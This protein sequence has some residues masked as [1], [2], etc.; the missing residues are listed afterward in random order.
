[1]VLEQLEIVPDAPPQAESRLQNKAISRPNQLD[2]APEHGKP[3]I[4]RRALLGT[5]VNIG[6]AMHGRGFSG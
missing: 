6:L 4:D 3:V 1:M 2:V 5:E